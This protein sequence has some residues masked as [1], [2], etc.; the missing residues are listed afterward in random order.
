[1]PLVLQPILADYLLRVRPWLLA[2]SGM[3][4]ERLWL[5]DSGEPY[6]ANHLYKRICR[7]TQEIVGTPIPP[8][9]FR[10]CVATTLAYHSPESAR[11]TRGVLGHSGFRMAERHYKQNQRSRGRSQLRQ[12]SRGDEGPQ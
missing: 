2:R 6:Q 12:S 4:T 9:F 8:H 7:I 11:L 10:D 1:M 3:P 5:N